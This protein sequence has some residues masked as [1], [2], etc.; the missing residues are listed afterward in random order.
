MRLF[1]STD[2]P[3]DVTFLVLPQSSMM[4]LAS[5][6]DTM[7]AA[8]RIAGRRLFSWEL[9]TLNGQPS[10]LTCDLVV[11]PDGSLGP[12]ASGDLLIVVASFNHQRHVGPSHLS[13]I[14]RVARRYRAIGGI[15]AGSWILARCGLLDDRAATTHWED[16]EEFRS[17]FPAIDVRTDRFVIDHNIFTTGGASPT[18]DL[19]LHL[20]QKRYGY[21]LAMEVSSVFLYDAGQSAADSQ[22]SV[23]LGLLETREPRVAAAIR[24]MEQHLDDTLSITQVAAQVDLSVRMLEYLF[25][26]TL[27]QTPA[28]YYRHLR[29]QVARKM[30]VD[31]RLPLQ[32]IAMRTGFNSLSVFSSVFRKHYGQSPAKH[33]RDATTLL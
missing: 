29:L 9:L 11:E 4:S 30:V 15:E 16:L 17:R 20:I 24:V 12:S 33:R 28:A 31:T 13:L 27:Q 19:V 21:A 23:S 22:A 25:K 14:K 3:L 32:E 1:E 8:N 7:R 18:F 2:R 26:R 5:A 6:L 10:R